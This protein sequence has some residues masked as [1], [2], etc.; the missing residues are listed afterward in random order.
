MTT[1]E[2]TMSKDIDELTA[3][4]RDYVAS[5]QNSDIKRF[6]E[7]LAD[8]FYCSNPDKSLVDRAGFLTQTAMPVTI[9]N[10]IADEVKIRVMGDFAI[11]HGRASY[12]TAEGQQAYGCYTDCWARQNGR[13]LAVSAHVSR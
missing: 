6:D 9:R 8:D 13:W 7:I 1:R 12:T 3:L 11:I 10:L 4:N 2:K 5:V